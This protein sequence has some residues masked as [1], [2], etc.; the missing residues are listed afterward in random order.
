MQGPQKL[1][2]TGPCEPCNTSPVGGLHNKR[3]HKIKT[4]PR[5]FGEA[6]GP[7]RDG[8]EHRARHEE[9]V[10]RSCST[11]PLLQ[12]IGRN[13]KGS[14]LSC[15]VEVAVAACG[16]RCER[17]CGTAQLGAACIWPPTP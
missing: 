7:N 10:S 14:P 17:T 11:T 15:H 9:T 8:P 12:E 16:G 5:E 1:R 13:L 2:L 3:Q 4:T 6:G